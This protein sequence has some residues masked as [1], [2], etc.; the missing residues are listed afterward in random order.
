MTPAVV[1]IAAPP[2]IPPTTPTD[3]AVN[4]AEPPTVRAD[5]LV[6]LSYKL[7]PVRLTVVDP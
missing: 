7:Q 4:F 6:E 2:D 1:V 5:A 3:K